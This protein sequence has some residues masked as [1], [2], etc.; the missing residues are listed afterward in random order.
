MRFL[1]GL[2]FFLRDPRGR[3]LDSARKSPAEHRLDLS[4]VALDNRRP[5]Q[6]DLKTPFR[7]LCLNEEPTMIRTL[8]PDAPGDGTSSVS[9]L[10]E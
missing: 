3:S 2:Q 4:E 7:P 5:D 9:S 10:K 1:E 8:V 6:G